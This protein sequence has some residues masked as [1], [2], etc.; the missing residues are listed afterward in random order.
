MPLPKAKKNA[1]LGRAIINKKA[2]DARTVRDG[3]S[4]TTDL[5]STDRLKSVTQERDLDEFLNTAQLA[6]TEFTAEKQNVIIIQNPDVGVSSA[7]NP[8]LLSAQEERE[9]V[10]KHQKNKEKLRVPRRPRWTKDLTAEQLER[11]ERDAFLEWRRGLAVLQEAENLVFTPFE[12][13]LEV[14]RQ[15]WRVL[16]RSHL[17]IQIVDARNP[18]RFRCEDLERY[19]PEVQDGYDTTGKSK[20]KRRSLL[21]I[22]KSDLLTTWQRKQWADYFDSQ[23][24]KFAFYSA[25]N[26][27]ALQEQQKAQEEILENVQE[28]NESAPNPDDAVEDSEEQVA[29][30]VSKL[31][32]GDDD[33]APEEN[34]N[35][36]EDASGETDDDDDSDDDSWDAGIP[37]VA[38]DDP[39]LDQDPR[40]KVLTVQ[41]LEE[42][43]IRSAPDLSDF[44]DQTGQVATRLVVGLVGYPNVGKSSTINS[45]I[46]AK[47]VSVSSTPGKTKHFQT[48]H[49]S[50]NMIL[51]DCPGLVFPQFANTKADL[52]CDGVLPID[53]MREH[54][55]PTT[56]VARR[57]PREILERT[58]GLSI[59]HRT[60][61][62][63]GDDQ[64]TG[65]DL[66]MSYAIARGFARSGQGNPDEARA[67]RYVLKD[68]V[69]AKLLFCHP[70]PT[71]SD[72]EFNAQTREIVLRRLIAAGK[73]KA[74]TT[75][76]GKDSDTFVETGGSSVLST[77]S[78]GTLPNPSLKTRALDS[79]FF[80]TQSS[81]SRAYVAG[82]GGGHEF[83]RAK[84]FPHQNAVADD[85]T[86]VSGRRARIAALLANQESGGSDKKH[87]KG[88]KHVKQR[89]GKGYD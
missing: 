43:F 46:G 61:E 7:H 75:R 78:P 82:S 83:T 19:V 68:Y 57:I 84:L 28:E 10:Q 35:E 51:C 30:D 5:D 33:I 67:A 64:V 29:E 41:E 11:Q 58:Y 76:V 13:N 62:E 63:G 37:A 79:N 72:D 48:I 81:M 3:N 23:G 12:R 15:L 74:P 60:E 69:N 86:A 31:S 40:T 55:G 50:Q 20:G 73:K 47:K 70:P 45:L 16:E 59:R 4:Y 54:T 17:V 38:G 24:V 36:A 26:A 56:L 66:L 18:L 85:G 9:T 6:G 44:T 34:E 32:L 1:G 21:L 39:E 80:D 65:E 52:V 2:K 22:N 42:L 88:K 14:W 25:L 77:P 87:H 49:L 53:Q 27:A 8:F 71:I 89:S